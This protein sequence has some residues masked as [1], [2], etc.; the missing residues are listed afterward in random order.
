MKYLLFF[1]GAFLAGCSPRAHD[2]LLGPSLRDQHARALAYGGILSAVNGE[3]LDELALGPVTDE[4]RRANQAMLAEWWEVKSREDFLATLAWIENGGHR[5]EFRELRWRLES[6]PV[7]HL[8]REIFKDQKD[9]RGLGRRFVVAQ[10]LRASR[11]KGLDIAAWDFG[12][13][14]NL[15]RWGYLSGYV[16]EQEAWARILPVAR[17]LQSSFASWDEFADDYF[18]GRAFW[19]V[20]QAENT[21]DLHRKAYRDLIAQGKWTQESWSSSLGRGEIGRD[22]YSLQLGSPN[23]PPDSNPPNRTGSP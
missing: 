2:F 16:T 3:S 6:V 9:I 22:L 20:D 5:K 19:S 7:E 21:G 13:Y 1:L 23:Q 11:R 18:L 8:M 12:R 10:V 17:F 14:I 15:C 4:I